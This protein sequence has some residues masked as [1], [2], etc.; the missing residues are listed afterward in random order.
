MNERL[1]RDKMRRKQLKS[2]HVFLNQ[3]KTKKEVV[4]T[5]HSSILH[6]PNGFVQDNEYI[7]IQHERMEKERIE[8][9]NMKKIEKERI[10]HEKREKEKNEREETIKIKEFSVR[11]MKEL[12]K[13]V[14]ENIKRIAKEESK[15]YNPNFQY[16]ALPTCQVLFKIRNHRIYEV[17]SYVTE[18]SFLKSIEILK[19]AIEIILKYEGME[20]KIQGNFI[21]HLNEKSDHEKSVNEIV[22]AKHQDTPK[23]LIPDLYCLRGFQNELDIPDFIPFQQKKQK[24]LFIGSTAGKEDVQQNERIQLCKYWD[25]QRRHQSPCN[26]EIYFYHI[27]QIK[28]EDIVSSFPTFPFYKKDE[29]SIQEQRNYRYCISID[30]NTSC[31]NRPIWILQ[32]NSLLLKK[33]S[34]NV[35]WYSSL[36]EKGKHYVEFEDGED[37][38]FKIDLLNRIFEKD[39]ERIHDIFMNAHQ[40]IKDYISPYAHDVYFGYVLHYMSEKFMI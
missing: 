6:S 40:F 8:K 34:K 15:Y 13:E 11:R 16:M 23:T 3:S 9:E 29:M 7:R 4:P 24:G 20:W 10:E 21:F 19:E 38:Y 30:G 5:T 22:F 35:S 25:S 17:K 12:S 14:L 31:W 32:S 28:E 1:M 2:S 39:P 18:E 36:M 27:C 26:F 37:L 33:N